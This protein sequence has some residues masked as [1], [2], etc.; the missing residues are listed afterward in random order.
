MCEVNDHDHRGSRTAGAALGQ[1]AEIAALQ[2]EIDPFTS[3]RATAQAQVGVT[4]A[5]WPNADLLLKTAVRVT[6]DNAV[7][8]LTSE[9]DRVTRPCERRRKQ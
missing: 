3:A 8:T 9:R 4:G 5:S 7:T 1:R 2:W 6:R